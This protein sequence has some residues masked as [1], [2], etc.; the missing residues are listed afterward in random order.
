[1]KVTVIGTGNMGG[2]LVR[3]LVRSGVQPAE[4]ITCT[5][6]SEST[7]AKLYAFN[8][9]LNLTTDN[10]AAVHGCDVVVIAV[11]P[12]VISTVIEQIAPVLDADRQCVVS[13]VAGVGLDD[14]AGMFDQWSDKIPPLC[15]AIPNT[16]IEL[17]CGVTFVTASD[18]SSQQ[19]DMVKG[20]FAALGKTYVVDEAHLRAG[21]ILA[22]CGIAYALRYIHAAAQ[23]GVEL[24]FRPAEAQDIVAHTVKGAA[25][26]LIANGSHAE[27]E[28]D[29]VTTAGG[30]TIRG[31]NAMEHA[32][33]SSAVIKG[34]KA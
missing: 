30:L 2:A 29:K 23:G 6:L 20:L 27:Q 10:I 13:M 25:E 4:D 34:L 15:I 19:M 16:A 24:G 28:I 11:K 5:A 31:L 8:P 21:T 17:L 12:W 7:I 18:L 9:A 3:G 26:L 33:F 32:G 14:L 1:M 22:S